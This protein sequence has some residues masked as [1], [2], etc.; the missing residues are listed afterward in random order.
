MSIL[1][2]REPIPKTKQ[3]QGAERPIYSAALLLTVTRMSCCSPAGFF[4]QNVADFSSGSVEAMYFWD[5]TPGGLERQSFSQAEPGMDDIRPFVYPI[6]I[7][8]NRD[9]NF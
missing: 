3:K 8:D 1:E 9:L 6:L 5:R 2:D 4:S 7:H